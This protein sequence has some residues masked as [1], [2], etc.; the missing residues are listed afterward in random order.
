M[1]L[2][3]EGV[4]AVRGRQVG[5]GLCVGSRSPHSQPVV[6]EQTCEA[7]GEAV[8]NGGDRGGWWSHV[9]LRWMHSP[10]SARAPVWQ[11]GP[12]VFLPEKPEIGFLFLYEIF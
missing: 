2:V 12:G 10:S 9:S 4:R 7:G 8:E 6:A 1:W 11:C 5:W 3:A